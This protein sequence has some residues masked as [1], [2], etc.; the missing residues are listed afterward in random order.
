MADDSTSA[1]TADLTQPAI[2]PQTAHAGEAPSEQPPGGRSLRATTTGPTEGSRRRSPASAAAG[3]LGGRPPARR[4]IEA[5]GEPASAAGAEP[6]GAP[7][8]SPRRS[9]ADG[10]GQATLATEGAVQHGADPNET[11]QRATPAPARATRNLGPASRRAIPRNVGVANP[12]P[13]R[14][15][16]PISDRAT[17]RAPSALGARRRAASPAPAP[18]GQRA[19]VDADA[20]GRPGDDWEAPRGGHDDD[21]DPFWGQLWDPPDAARRTIDLAAP[22]TPGPRAPVARRQ[23]TAA[24]PPRAGPPPP[25]PP[26]TAGTIGLFRAA[27][28]QPADVLASIRAPTL[29]ELNAITIDAIHL[30]FDPRRAAEITRPRGTLD[31]VKAAQ[32]LKAQQTLETKGWG[33]SALDVDFHGVYFGPQVTFRPGQAPATVALLM[34]WAVPFGLDTPGDISKT[35]EWAA[36]LDSAASLYPQLEAE[37]FSCRHG[38]REFSMPASLFS[39]IRALA[40]AYFRLRATALYPL[41]DK[42]GTSAVEEQ[43]KTVVRGYIHQ[44]ASLP[45]TWSHIESMID[46]GAL[47]QHGTEPAQAENAARVTIARAFLVSLIQGQTPNWGLADLV[48]SHTEYTPSATLLHAT[49][50]ARLVQT[51]PAAAS[52]AASLTPISVPPSA[53]SLPGRP[54]TQTPPAT[55]AQPPALMPPAPGAAP[56]SASEAQLGFRLGPQGTRTHPLYYSGEYAVPPGW[57]PPPPAQITPQLP[58]GL[59]PPLAGRAGQVPRSSALSIPTARQIVTTSSPFG[60][61]SPHPCNYCQAPGHAQYECP[62]RFA[63][64]YRRPLPGFT[65]QGDFDQTAWHNGEL[66]PPARAAMAGYLREL[67][68]PAHRKYGVTIDHILAGTAPPPPI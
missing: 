24:D 10:G 2:S 3:G 18:P 47:R 66:T 13:A 56:L 64:T 49:D 61:S 19:R 8:T 9:P 57:V 62:R 51:M 63:D 7:R 4:P 37:V 48:Q 46:L 26:P 65:M 1:V 50:F 11:S 17:L 40:E 45:G 23:T 22:P 30:L 29:K 21:E 27:R 54:L 20:W 59:P 31:D 36:I 32:F 15:G 60:N 53:Y 43:A 38:G 68:I 12:A 52:L 5:D 6:G 39:K 33:H 34:Q 25:A 28:E 67:K 55:T 16:R 42:L 35:N 41:L 14:R 44:A 58:A